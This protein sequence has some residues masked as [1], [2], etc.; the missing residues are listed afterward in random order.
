MTL[1]L[2]LAVAWLALDAVTAALHILTTERGDQM[3][4][5][6][7][8]RRIAD[9]L[10]ATVEEQRRELW[11]LSG[12]YADLKAENAELER[13]LAART[14]PRKRIAKVT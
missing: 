9:G 13:K 7:I 1:I 2:S 5:P 6:W 8:R 4:W 14:A 11:Q 10:M 3:R 12:Q